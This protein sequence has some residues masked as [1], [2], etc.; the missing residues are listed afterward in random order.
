MESVF[1]SA[2]LA[3]SGW[4]DL[5]MSFTSGSVSWRF[6]LALSSFFAIITTFTISLMP[7][8][9]RWLLKKGRTEEAREAMAA[10]NALSVDDPQL[11]IDIAEIN[12]SLTIASRGRF[13]DCFRNGELRYLNRAG[14]ACAGQC[15][16]Q[17]CGVRKPTDRRVPNITPRY[18]SF[19]RPLQMPKTCWEIWDIC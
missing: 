8:S 6:P 4:V 11:D 2:G 12:S 17:V 15:F 7:E 5:G 13:I 3:L 1:I 19:W 16:Q 18:A 14:L 9:P 10:L